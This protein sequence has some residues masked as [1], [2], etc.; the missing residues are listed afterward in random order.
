MSRDLLWRN[1]PDRPP[2]VLVT[3]ASS[4]IGRATALQ[5]AGRGVRLVLVARSVQS[6]T[7]A[8]RQCRAAGATV[9]VVPADVADADAVEGAFAAAARRFGQVDAVVHAAAVVAYGRFE[10]VP[11][12]AFDRVLSTNLTGTANVARSALLHFKASGGGRLVVVGSLLGKIAAPFMASYV[13][14]KWAVHG[15]VRTIQVEARSVPGLEVSLVSPGGVDTPVYHQAASWLGRQGRPPP[16]VDPP[17]KVAHAV[18]RALE[19]PRR[20]SSVGPANPV[21]VLG[22]RAFPAVFDALVTP[23]M[24]LGGLGRDAVEPHEGNVFEPRPAGDAVHGQWGRHWLRP[25]GAVGAVG[26]V[27]G[28]AAGAVRWAGS[29]RAKVLG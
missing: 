23:L 5:L 19:R 9:L 26:A 13:T 14:S 16:P 11:T 8:A 3:G 28:A 12:A 21:V 7:A 18:V 2:V 6:L 22:F 17:E 25:V 24:R 20:E 1:G 4:G 29:R 15:L 27:A 10:E